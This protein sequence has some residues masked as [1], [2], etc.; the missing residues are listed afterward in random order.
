MSKEESLRNLYYQEKDKNEESAALA[1]YYAQQSE[2]VK[3]N[4]EH[5]WSGLKQLTR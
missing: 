3:Q 4:S 2:K 5:F 1:Y